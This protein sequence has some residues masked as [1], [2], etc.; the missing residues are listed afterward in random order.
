MICIQKSAKIVGLKAVFQL[1]S[2]V[3]IIGQKENT[4]FITMAV[5][6]KTEFL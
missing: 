4:S 5:L 3:K 6:I 1:F 2:K